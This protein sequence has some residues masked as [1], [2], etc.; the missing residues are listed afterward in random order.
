[1]LLGLHPQGSNAGVARVCLVQGELVHK[2]GSALVRRWRPHGPQGLQRMGHCWRVQEGRRRVAAGQALRRGHEAGQAL[3]G[4]AAGH[5]RAEP[6]LQ[7]QVAAE[8]THG[9]RL[10]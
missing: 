3:Q 9:C 4:R 2:G 1:M 5:R 8:R 6:R 10:R 7:G